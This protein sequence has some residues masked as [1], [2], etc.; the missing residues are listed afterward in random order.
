ML[1]S[2]SET[3]HIS[4]VMLMPRHEI[5]LYAM[6]GSSLYRPL[7][8]FYIFTR[9]ENQPLKQCLKPKTTHYLK[10]LT[11]HFLIRQVF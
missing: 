2:H 1:W 10:K 8:F 6:K 7:I 11:N 3:E 5:Q 9:V 4:E